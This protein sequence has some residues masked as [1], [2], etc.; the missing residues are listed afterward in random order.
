[1]GFLAI[2]TASGLTPSLRV[3][4]AVLL[5]LFSI[6]PAERPLSVFF[7]NT[8]W[9]VFRASGAM[10]VRAGWLVC[11]TEELGSDFLAMLDVSSDWPPDTGTIAKLKA[12]KAAKLRLE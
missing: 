4:S 10:V 9:T 7:D 5:A 3:T 2:N 1:V 12:P 6:V 11:L 8:D